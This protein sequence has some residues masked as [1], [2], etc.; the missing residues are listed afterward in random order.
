MN[1]LDLSYTFTM[2]D[3]APVLR[4]TGDDVVVV[5]VI[6][7]LSCSDRKI[8]KTFDHRVSRQK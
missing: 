4:H 5:V 1:R 7:Q 2:S 8:K 3:S 6:A